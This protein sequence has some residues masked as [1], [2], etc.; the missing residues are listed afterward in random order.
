MSI[1]IS[2]SDEGVTSLSFPVERA[3]NGGVQQRSYNFAVEFDATGQADVS[4]QNESEEKVNV[5]GK[6]PTN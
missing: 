2:T 4:I 6:Q 1:C 3:S 5:I